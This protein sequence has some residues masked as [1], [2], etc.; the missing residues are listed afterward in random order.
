MCSAYIRPSDSLAGSNSGLIEFR[1]RSL[2][3]GRRTES[4]IGAVPGGWIGRSDDRGSPI[5]PPFLRPLL[6]S[7][8]LS[9]PPVLWIPRH[10]EGDVTSLTDSQVT[11]LAWWETWQLIPT[12]GTPWHLHAR[13]LMFYFSSSLLGGSF[14]NR[15]Y[16]DRFNLALQRKVFRKMYMLFNI[17][18]S[19][20]LV[21]RL[22]RY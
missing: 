3:D 8:L 9:N 19:L 22:N 12:S 21:S 4:R 17:L 18:F 20:N 13:Q 11:Q 14:Q 10:P 15:Y 7:Q 2:G 16:I 5:H 1:W 6:L